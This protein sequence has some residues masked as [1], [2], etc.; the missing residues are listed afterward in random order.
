MLRWKRSPVPYDVINILDDV[1]PNND[2]IHELAWFLELLLPLAR[3]NSTNKVKLLSKVKMIDCHSFAIMPFPRRGGKAF[4]P[5][6]DV[7]RPCDVTE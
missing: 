6:Y 1:N 2:D 3:K 4:L 5:V 7:I